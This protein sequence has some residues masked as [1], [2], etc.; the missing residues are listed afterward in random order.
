MSP[1]R[2]RRGAAGAKQAGRLLLVGA[3]VVAGAVFAVMGG[4]YSTFDLLR[5]RA[6]VDSLQTEVAALERT[7]DSLAAWKTAI[8][9]DSAT[10][11]RLAR[12]NFGMV[13][14]DKELLYRFAPE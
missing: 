7:V 1:A 14:G 3:A 13:R 12:E 11:E 9:T 5:Q 6:L 8:E 10:Q 4:E 2:P